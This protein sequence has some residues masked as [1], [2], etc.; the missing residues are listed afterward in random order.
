MT[1]PSLIPRAVVVTV[2]LPDGAQCNVWVFTDDPH[3]VEVEASY[4]KDRD[5]IWSPPLP[6]LVEHQG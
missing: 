2:D 1:D 3:R 4:R 6:V 5:D